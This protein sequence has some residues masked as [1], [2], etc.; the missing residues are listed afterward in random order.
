MLESEIIEEEKVGPKEI[1]VDMGINPGT[2]K[3][4]SKDKTLK[5]FISNEL[6]KYY[7]K[8]H[9]LKKFK[10]LLENETNTSK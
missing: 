6:G 3:N 2:A 4:I 10:R 7:L 1:A 8:N 9:D 5:K